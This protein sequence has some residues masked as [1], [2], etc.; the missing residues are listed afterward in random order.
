MADDHSIIVPLGP[1]KPADDVGIAGNAEM[2][3]YERGGHGFAVRDTGQPCT[4][5]TRSCIAWLRNQG[6]LKAAPRE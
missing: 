6:M 5:W 4:L 1:G 3:L 2:H